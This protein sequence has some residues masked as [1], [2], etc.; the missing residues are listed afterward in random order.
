METLFIPNESDFRKWI[1]EALKETLELSATKKKQ[2]LAKKKNAF[3]KQW[4]A[5]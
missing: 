3:V 1:R 4:K 2:K 5:N